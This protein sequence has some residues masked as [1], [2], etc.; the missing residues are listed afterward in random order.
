MMFLLGTAIDGA[1]SLLS[2]LQQTGASGAS[3]TSGAASGATGQAAPTFDATGPS[4]PAPSTPSGNAPNWNSGVMTALL[5][6]QEQQQGAQGTG[7]SATLPPGLARLFNRTDLNGDGQIDRSELEKLFGASGTAQADAV[8]AKLDSNNDGAISPSEFVSAARGHGHLHHATGGANTGLLG[9]QASNTQGTTSS[10]TTNPD[11]STITT[12][13]Y[14]DGSTVTMTTP[15]TNAGTTPSGNKGGSGN[16][17][18]QLINLQAQLS[19]VPANAPT[20]AL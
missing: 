20:T 10:T 1:L 3:G 15:A 16:L 11:G 12:I 13:T 17:L 6:A 5:A 18:E 7:A 14:A 8:F 2:S 4:T 19:S 9:S